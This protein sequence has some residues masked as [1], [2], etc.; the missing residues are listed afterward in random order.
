MDHAGRRHVVRAASRPPGRHRLIG[1]PATPRRSMLLRGRLRTARGR[2]PHEDR[3]HAVVLTRKPDLPPCPA[4]TPGEFIRMGHRVIPHGLSQLSQ[5]G[6]ARATGY[7]RLHEMVIAV[8][9]Y[10]FRCI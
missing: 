10:E 3:C 7:G 1:M 2:R 8:W 4:C 9:S 6:S 5:A